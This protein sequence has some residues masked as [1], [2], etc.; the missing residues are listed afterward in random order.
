MPYKDPIE[1]RKASARYYARHG[2]RA[3]AS[4]TAW[5]NRGGWA[6]Q[7]STF[8]KRMY[9][10]TL[11]DYRRM[12]SERCGLCDICGEPPTSGIGQCLQV[13]HD[14]A[15]GKVRGLLC[16]PCNRRLGHLEHGLFQ[17]SM[18]YLRRFQ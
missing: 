6:V 9:G 2:D 3:R 4:K 13:D 18:E 14:H 1:H 8:L 11:D 17:K 7:K 5:R 15:T 10:I 16:W 12:V